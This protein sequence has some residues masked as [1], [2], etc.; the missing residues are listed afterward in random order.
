MTFKIILKVLLFAILR[1][2]TFHITPKCLTDS[3]NSLHSQLWIDYLIGCL[4]PWQSGSKGKGD[5]R[6]PPPPP[7]CL[8]PCASLLPTATPQLGRILR[9][10]R[11]STET[12]I[13]LHPQEAGGT[14]HQVPEA[15]H[16][17]TKC[18]LLTGLS[19]AAVAFWLLWTTWLCL[20]VSCSQGCFCPVGPVRPAQGLLPVLCS[21][22]L[23][24]PQIK[25]WALSILCIL[26]KLYLF[27]LFLHCT[28]SIFCFRIY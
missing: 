15:V 14:D 9:G 19:E 8:T 20:F 24:V 18:N 16:L 11:R 25:R 17:E 22:Q 4:L 13:T 21:F 23:S 12:K 7:H 2:K 5:P 28:L 26:E 6:H 27:T 3:G 10:Q 1:W